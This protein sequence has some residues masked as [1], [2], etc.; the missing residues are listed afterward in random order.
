MFKF[1]VQSA[2]FSVYYVLIAFLNELVI[3]Y[4]Q[5]PLA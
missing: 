2:T 1:L 5:C 4:I 3:L